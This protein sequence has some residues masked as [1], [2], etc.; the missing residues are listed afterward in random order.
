AAE[1]SND[2]GG[3][4]SKDS[5]TPPPPHA[6]PAR[7]I[8]RDELSSQLQARVNAEA[9]PRVAALEAQLRAVELELKRVRED[10][11]VELGKI[12]QAHGGA[13]RERPAAIRAEAAAAITPLAKAW[14]TEPTRATALALIELLPPL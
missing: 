2:N 3:T 5:T 11:N 4:D 13:G 6:W 8:E 7:C 14:C 12:Q 9:A 1:S 10:W